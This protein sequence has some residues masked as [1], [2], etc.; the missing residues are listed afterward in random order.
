MS[1]DLALWIPPELVE[2]MVERVLERLRVEREEREPPSTYVS[3]AEAA[4]IIRARP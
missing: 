2:A 4:E 1:G 3:V